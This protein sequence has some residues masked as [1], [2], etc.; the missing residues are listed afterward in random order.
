MVCRIDGPKLRIEYECG[1]LLAEFSASVVGIAKMNPA[2][3]ATV[4][5]LFDAI[6]EAVKFAHHPR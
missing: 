4:A 2:I 3:E 5:N 6:G 1:D